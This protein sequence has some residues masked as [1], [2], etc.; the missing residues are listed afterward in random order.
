M[1]AFTRPDCFEFAMG[2]IGDPEQAELR[3]YIEA[4]EAEL[5]R[6]RLRLA[7]CGVVAMADTPESAAKARD[8]HPDYRSASLDDVIRQVDA[9]IEL[10]SKL[11][12]QE[13]VRASDEQLICAY[14]EAYA[15][16][17]NR[18]EHYGCHVDGLRAVLRL[19]GDQVRQALIKA[20]CALADI[21]EGEPEG[22]QDSADLLQWAERRA[23]S[24]LEQIRPVMV[25]FGVPTSEWP[26]N[27]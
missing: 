18:G 27:G 25:E 7:A 10:C 20:E 12:Q 17:W 19:C 26:P 15:P 13:Q 3:G 2:F 4:L 14:Q 16:A 22:S 11:G 6:E 21:A 1:T 5:E 9:L 23:A 8:I 24:A